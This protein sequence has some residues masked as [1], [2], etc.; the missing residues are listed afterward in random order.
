MKIRK[1][2]SNYI[3]VPG[4]PLVKNGY[5]VLEEGAVKEV[6]DTGG[7]IKEIQGLEFYGGFLV[8][9]CGENEQETL[10]E[11]EL[12]L[13]WLE[14]LYHSSGHEKVGVGILEGADLLK[15]VWKTGAR[16]RRLT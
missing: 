10:R 6:V 2:A 14:A 15:L 3:F 5:V 4:F 9:A 13:P 11:G 7:V 12:L 8:A 1:I 16:F